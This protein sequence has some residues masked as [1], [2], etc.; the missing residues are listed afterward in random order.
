LH[1]RFADGVGELL[2]GVADPRAER[3][4]CETERGVAD[5]V[6]PRAVEVSR[7]S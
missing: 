7:W 3:A 6:V 2:V 1:E 4:P 5:T